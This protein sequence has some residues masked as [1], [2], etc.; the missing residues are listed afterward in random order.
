[1]DICQHKWVY[2]GT[3]SGDL[4]SN[5]SNW[6][7]KCIVCKQTDMV[8]DSGESNEHCQHAW[9]YKG[10]FDQK[11]WVKSCYKCENSENIPMMQAIKE[12]SSANDIAK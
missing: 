12:S 3:I 2:G 8:T 4:D 11:I 7:R 9:G 5:E 1:M 6:N 10:T